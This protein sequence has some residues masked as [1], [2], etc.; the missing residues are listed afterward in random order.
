M[1]ALFVALLLVGVSAV[2]HAD[3]HRGATK[4]N[5]T[6]YVLPSLGGPT[7]G[8]YF[9]QKSAW[10]RSDAN[11]YTSAAQAEADL[12]ARQCNDTESGG[13]LCAY[14]AAPGS[15]G[16]RVD[17]R[18]ANPNWQT[19]RACGHIFKTKRAAVYSCPE[20][21]NLRWIRGEGVQCDCTDLQL[22]D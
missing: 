10:Y 21:A 17:R 5:P 16:A 8:E 18:E 12:E 4:G 1:K 9:S 7:G 2:A 11:G 6:N 15:R 3:D 19:E 22:R 14:E 13:R 20:V